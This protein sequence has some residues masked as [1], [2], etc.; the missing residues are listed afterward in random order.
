MGL[1]RIDTCRRL[2]H[3]LKLTPVTSGRGAEAPKGHDEQSGRAKIFSLIG[4]KTSA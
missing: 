4:K 2:L 1:T 3:E